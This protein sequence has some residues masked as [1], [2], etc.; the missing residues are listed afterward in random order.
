MKETR[1]SADLPRVMHRIRPRD[2][3]GCALS[4]SFC[5]VV[6]KK[7]LLTFSTDAPLPQKQKIDPFLKSLS[8]QKEDAESFTL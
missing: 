4:P 7:L 5:F 1:I 2:K 6:R 3:L 8:D